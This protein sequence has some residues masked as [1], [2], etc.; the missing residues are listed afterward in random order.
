[1]QLKFPLPRGHFEGGKN[2]SESFDPGALV[3]CLND[4]GSRPTYQDL[5]EAYTVT[6]DDELETFRVSGTFTIS[7]PADVEPG[8]A[9]R[10]VQT[11]AGTVS[12]DDDGGASTV[13]S[14]PSLF[15]MGGVG[16][17]VTAECIDVDTWLL[18]GQLA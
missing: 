8:T 10:F 14:L 4:L 6:Q 3:Y 16:A 5:T 9:M 18:V 15:D 12:F 17:T 2:V 7:L 13:I 11:G 1:M